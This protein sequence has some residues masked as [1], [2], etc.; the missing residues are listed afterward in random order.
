VQADVSEA[1]LWQR[2]TG[3]PRRDGGWVVVSDDPNGVTSAAHLLFAKAGQLFVLFNQA[4][5]WSGRCGPS[6]GKVE[7][8]GGGTVPW[9]ATLLDSEAYTSLLCEWPDGKHAPCDG[10]TDG[11]P[12]QSYCT[13]TSHGEEVVIF[14]AA[15]FEGIVSISALAQP[16]NEQQSEPVSLIANDFQPTKVVARVCGNRQEVPYDLG[17][18]PTPSAGSPP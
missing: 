6:G 11:N 12:V 8:A 9:H 2:M 10:S 4:F 14:D 17:A 18:K 13:W 1:D 3:G 15:S 7:L 5:N 16:R